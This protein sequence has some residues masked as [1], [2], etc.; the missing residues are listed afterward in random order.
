MGSVFFF[1][2]N[3]NISSLKFQYGFTGYKTS[4]AQ[5]ICI[6]VSD[7]LPQKHDTY[8]SENQPLIKIILQPSC[9]Y[10]CKFTQKKMTLFTVLETF[11][12]YKLRPPLYIAP[13][14]SP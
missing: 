9:I 14:L 13:K 2:L 10:F 3:L 7:I 8:S 6:C 4:N 5:Y 12:L 1:L 11:Y